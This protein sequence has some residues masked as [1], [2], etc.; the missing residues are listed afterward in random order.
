[1]VAVDTAQPLGSCIVHQLYAYRRNL[2][3]RIAVLAADHESSRIPVQLEIA[4]LDKTAAAFGTDHPTVRRRELRCRCSARI[5]HTVM[6][7]APG[8]A[9]ERPVTQPG[10]APE[11]RSVSAN[12]QWLRATVKLHNFRWLESVRRTG[13]LVLDPHDVGRAAKRDFATAS[14]IYE[15]GHRGE[16]MGVIRLAITPSAEAFGRNCSLG[17]AAS[18]CC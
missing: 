13:V 2:P 9:V 11:S 18:A 16:C 17:A 4:D 1:M 15:A 14:L 8:D 6:R 7:W 10:R 12:D 5:W 3:P